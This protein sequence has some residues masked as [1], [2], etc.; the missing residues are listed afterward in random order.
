MEI[1]KSKKCLCNQ[2]YLI[3]CMLCIVCAYTMGSYLAKLNASYYVL[4]KLDCKT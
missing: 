1:R 2:L 4:S 3:R